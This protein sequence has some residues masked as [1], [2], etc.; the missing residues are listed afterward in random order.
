MKGTFALGRG[1]QAFLSHHLGDL[2]HWEAYRAFVRDIGL[3]QELFEYAELL[4][5]DLHSDYASTT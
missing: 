3:Y 1:N 4:V 2:D 5:H